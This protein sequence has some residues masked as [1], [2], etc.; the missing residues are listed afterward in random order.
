[1]NDT[2]Q[3]MDPQ[4]EPQP[5]KKNLTIPELK[6]KVC[7]AIQTKFSSAVMRERL[8]HLAK[9][10]ESLVVNNL[11]SF[12]TIIANDEGAGRADN[13][14]YLCQAST[15]SLSLCFLESMQIGI[16]IDRRGLV[17]IVV[18]GSQAE[19]EIDYKGFIY[20]LNKHYEQATFDV[21]LVFEGDTFTHWSESGDDKYSYKMGAERKGNDYAKVEWAYCFITY[22]KGGREHS[23][24]EVMDKKEL[25]LVRSKAKTKNV[26][27]EWTGEMYKKAV[28]RRAC[29]LP[30]A[31]VDENAI[32]AIDNKNFQLERPASADR[33]QLL[34]KNQKEIIGDDDPA[35]T[36]E[37][38]P[39][40]KEAVAQV[41]SG[42]SS[43]ETSPSAAAEQEP[44]QEAME[45]GTPMDMPPESGNPPETLGSN[46]QPV[47]EAQYQQ[48]PS[49]NDAPIKY[50]PESTPKVWDGKTL[51]INGKS[52][53][54]E[55]SSAAN[56]CDYLR[57]VMAQRKHKTSRK[58]MIEANTELMT[59][60]IKSGNGSLIAELHK[61]ADGGI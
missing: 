56:A 20:Y 54:K 18:Y 41:Q 12:L 7:Q 26:W 4:Q 30:L 61:L 46:S 6:A 38:N 45:P 59:A 53:S 35:K 21:K 3:K 16:P 29:K 15:S 8:M 11:N 37:K 10:D 31:A 2:A 33:L 57:T 49:E 36:A 32:E 42:G 48:V 44:S 34:L 1:M 60:L 5:E 39:P 50:S 14:K 51:Y 23:K 40:V 13:K 22:M 25:N 47:I 9:G 17:H 28:V 55:F 19:L 58:E 52:V 24:I 27:D 43:A